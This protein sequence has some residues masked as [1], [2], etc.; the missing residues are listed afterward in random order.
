LQHIHSH[1]LVIRI[2]MTGVLM[3]FIISHGLSSYYLL[4]Q[5][6][7]LVQFMDTTDEHEEEKEEKSV[8]K[9]PEFRVDFE[10]YSLIQACL[11]SLNQDAFMGD[12]HLGH[13][14]ETP[15]PPPEVRIG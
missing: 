15:T 10:L 7:D 9:H 8:E 5:S 3:S 6:A 4:S 14:A 12:L 2:L 1:F 11:R 13:I